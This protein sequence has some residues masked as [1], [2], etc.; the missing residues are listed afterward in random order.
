[1]FPF[2]GIRE[3]MK[4]SPQEPVNFEHQYWPSQILMIL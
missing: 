2:L 1:M 4:L 3:Y